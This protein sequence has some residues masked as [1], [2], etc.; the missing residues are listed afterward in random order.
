MLIFHM[1]NKNGFLELIY[2]LYVGMGQTGSK[3]WPSRPWSLK[4]HGSV[5]EPSARPNAKTLGLE[6]SE[7][8]GRKHQTNMDDLQFSGNQNRTNLFFSCSISPDW[9]QTNLRFDHNQKIRINQMVSSIAIYKTWPSFSFL[10]IGDIW[11]HFNHQNVESGFGTF[12]VA[13]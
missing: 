4:A 9:S 6:K 10:Y 2:F 7:S 1:N 5:C 12:C 8:S 3:T 11:P 13:K